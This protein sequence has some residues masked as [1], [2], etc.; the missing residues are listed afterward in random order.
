[1]SLE[2]IFSKVKQ[3]NLKELPIV[4]KTDV[5]GT[6]E[7][8]KGVLSKLGNEEVKV[9]VIHNAVGGISE[10]DVMLAHTSGGLIIGFNVRPDVTAQRAAKEKGVEIKTYSIIYNLS[11]D[12]KKAMSGLL[13]P[14]V[15]EEALGS[16]EVREIFSVP[17][18]GVIAGSAVTDGKIT[19]NSMLRLVREGRVIYEGKII[20]LRRFKDDAKEVQSG[21]ECGIGIENYNDIKVGDVIEA[22]QTKEVARELE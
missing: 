20:S 12:I 10:N 11:D 15:V 21:Y 16:A 8:I 13:D 7:A 5:A 14:D 19:R 6:A 18:L 22:Y 9:N 2:D 17:K 4:L 1:M 3:G